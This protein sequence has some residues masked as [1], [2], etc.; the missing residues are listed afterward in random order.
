M[1]Y[2]LGPYLLDTMTMVIS[3]D[4]QP[5]ICDDRVVMLLRL[6]AEHYPGHCEA[7]LLLNQLWPKRVVSVSSLARLVSDCR[8]FFK[9][10]GFNEPLIQTV[11]GRGYRL[12]HG[13]LKPAEQ[14]G[15][16]A[17]PIRRS[18]PVL[19]GVGVAM[20]FSLVIGVKFLP[21]N[22]AA[23]LKIAEPANVQSRILWVD[24]H[25]QNNADEIDHFEQHQIAVYKVTSTKD[26]L[27]LLDMYQYQLIIS[28]MGR[29]DNPLAGLHLV[30][31]IR[32]T[33]IVTP[34]I[35]YTIIPSEA[36]KKI[37]ISYGANAVAVDKAELFTLANQWI[38]QTE[39]LQQQ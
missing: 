26:A 14:S 22:S 33:G 25:P 3:F 38:A 7:Q 4:N 28:D 29:N 31:A 18:K 23:S 6:L 11:H 5:L 27:A 9:S 2:E 36:Q 19:A 13:V 32:K 8:V 34:Y 15:S 20:A 21:F 37:A 1:R 17:N 30:E 39:T 35:I 10:H 12:A 24:D 16:V